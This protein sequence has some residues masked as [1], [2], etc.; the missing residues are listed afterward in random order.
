MNIVEGDLLNCKANVIVQQLNC[1][2]TRPHG[3]S[4][5]IADKWEYADVYRKR[6]SI[7]GNRNLA[8][9]NDRPEPGTISISLPPTTLDNVFGF[10]SGFPIV[11]GI[12]GQYD[13]GKYYFKQGRPKFNQQNETKELRETWFKKGL[14][15][16][17]KW[18]KLNNHNN[19][20]FTIGFPFKIGCGLAGGNWK[21]YHGMIKQFECEVDCTIIIYKID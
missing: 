17:I 2:T 11:I 13:Y 16:L 14:E 20:T 19:D 3:L 4:S 18:I 21:K 9:P 6:K 10:R 1:L 15:E 12:Y 5:A 7:S 8:A